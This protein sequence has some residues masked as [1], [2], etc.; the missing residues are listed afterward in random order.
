[1]DG[2]DTIPPSQV[3]VH[4]YLHL[5]GVVI[6]YYDHA[7]TFDDEY[8]RVWQ[9][10]RTGA[11]ILFLVN[12]YFAFITNIAI[13]AGNFGAFKSIQGCA[14]YTFYRQLS[15]IIAQVIVAG[16]SSIIFLWL[17]AVTAVHSYPVLEDVCTLWTRP[18]DHD[19]RAFRISCSL[20]PL[21]LGRHR[22][23]IHVHACTRVSRSVLT[24][25]SNTHRRRM[26][27]VVHLGP[28][29]IFL[30]FLQIYQKPQPPWRRTQQP[31]Q[32][33]SARWS[34]ILWSDGLRSVL[35]YVD[36]LFLSASAPWLSINVREQHVCNDDVPP[37]AQSTSHCDGPVAQLRRDDRV[38]ERRIDKY[39][40]Y[41]A[42]RHDGRACR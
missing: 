27:S 29:N 41:V 25:I 3:Y 11:S 2:D 14:H 9:N 40:L 10:P 36:L 1:M 34:G 37:H 21:R 16:M 28:S 38:R 13:T 30:D 39:V 23:K 33:D 22:P 6:L 19:R 35:E 5:L 42:L 26:G 31:G 32:S 8:W 7:I 17:I 20:H 15:L 12:R 4:N 24:N 18:P